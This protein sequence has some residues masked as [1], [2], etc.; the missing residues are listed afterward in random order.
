MPRGHRVH[1]CHAVNLFLTDTTFFTS[2]T[3]TVKKQ[4]VPEASALQITSLNN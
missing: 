1:Q 4:P 2:P 3:L